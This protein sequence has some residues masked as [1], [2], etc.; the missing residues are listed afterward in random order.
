MTSTARIQLACILSSLGLCSGCA[1]Y[2]I[3]IVQPAEFAQTI[4]PKV[5]VKIDINPVEYSFADD[6][7]L[8]VRIDNHND[9]PVTIVGERSYVVDPEGQ[10]HGFRGGSIAPHSYIA[11][12]IPPLEYGNRGGPHF[13]IGVGVGGRFMIR[14]FIGGYYDEPFYP[15]SRYDGP[16]PAWRWKTGQVRLHLVY[17][18][19]EDRID[20]EFV[21]ERRRAK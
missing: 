18:F 1:T 13:G 4:D 17:E 16:S 15:Y 14:Q 11:F 7:G 10:S 12:R 21:F 20:H 19:Q 5:E 3:D 9:D 8:L 6:V 2:R